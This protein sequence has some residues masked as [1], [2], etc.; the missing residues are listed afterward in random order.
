[1]TSEKKQVLVVAKTY[2]NLSK[3]YD[4]TVCTAGIDLKTNSWIRIFPIRFFDLPYSQRFSKYH[5]IEVE[6]ERT[7]DKFTR[8]E[9]HRANDDSIRV[10]RKIDTNNNWKERKAILLPLLEKSVEELQAQYKQDHTSMGIIKPKCIVDFKATPIER[11]RPWEKDLVMGIQQ[12]L[13][14]ENYQSPLEKIPYKFSYIFECNDPNCRIKHDLMIEDWE[15]CQ[16]YRSEKQR[17]GETE[18]LQKVSQKY[19]E[20]FTTKKDL[21]FILGTES[22]WNNWLIISVFYPKKE[23]FA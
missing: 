2:P 3:K 18:A 19:K 15:I 21:Y 9:S 16:L 10:L 20:E 14:G 11:C 8:K 5:V 22:N 13:D 12:T 23:D 17:V 1:M 4:R 7:N 6:V